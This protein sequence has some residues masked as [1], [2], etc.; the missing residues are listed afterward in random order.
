MKVPSLPEKGQPLNAN[1]ERT[2]FKRLIHLE[3][4]RTV[5]MN[6]VMQQFVRLGNLALDTCAE[7]LSVVKASLLPL[8]H[9]WLKRCKVDASK[10]VDKIPQLIL[11]YAQYV[12][13]EQLDIDGEKQVCNFAEVHGTPVEANQVRAP[14]DLLEFPDGHS[15]LQTFP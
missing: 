14:L 6:E 8:N 10:V 15:A 4:S 3:Q 7:T 11:L 12:Q 9:T 1:R 5:C 2:V 13:K